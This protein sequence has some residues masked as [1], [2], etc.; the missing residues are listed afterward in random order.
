MPLD[1][2]YSYSYAV[3]ELEN[4]RWGVF[5]LM[6]KKIKIIKYKKL[7]I[8]I[9][10]RLACKSNKMLD[11]VARLTLVSHFYFYFFLFFCLLCLNLSA[12]LVSYIILIILY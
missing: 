12:C 2:C 11:M 3:V 10:F 7:I 6:N 9:L 8:F 1:F 4:S 5:F